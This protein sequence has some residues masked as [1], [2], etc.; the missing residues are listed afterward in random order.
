MNEFSLAHL[1][2]L[3]LSPPEMVNVAART[4]Y[5]TIGLRLIA[6][7][8]DSP[9]YP[10]M[11][12]P[13]AMRDTKARLDDTGIRIG[14]IEFVKITPEIDIMSLEPFAAAGA[15]LGAR[16]IIAAPYDPDLGRL[17]ERFAALADL[18]GQYNLSVLLEFFPWTVVPDVRTAT[19]IVEKA[20]RNNTGVLVDTLHFARSG[21][22]LE[23]LDLISPARLPFVHVC[24]AVAG[25]P[26]TTEQLLHTARSERLPPGD[27]GIDISGILKRLPADIVIGLEVPMDTL[28][29]ECGPEEVA[30]RVR[31]AAGRLISGI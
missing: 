11:F 9:G 2:V 4:G 26:F 16:H 24:D 22:R 25:E 23:D 5:D 19:R 14:D 12:D 20:D 21:S 18:A 28:T 8:A 30:R 7:T 15:E 13:P 31:A 10:L 27:G 17:A 29:R 3:S 6:V 1:T